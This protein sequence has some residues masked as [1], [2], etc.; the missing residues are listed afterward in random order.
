MLI[1]FLQDYRGKLT[2]ELFYVKGEEVEIADG[3]ALQ[4][5][6]AGRAQAVEAKAPKP[7][8]PK[9]EAGDGKTA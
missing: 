7:S 2:A 4:L 1:R 8:K 9:K 6:E 5:I 3:P